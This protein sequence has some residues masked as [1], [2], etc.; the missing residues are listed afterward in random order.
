MSDLNSRQSAIEEVPTEQP[1]I[2]RCKDCKWWERSLNSPYGY[3]NAMKHIYMSAHWEIRMI[4]RYK[5]DFY[6]ADAERNEE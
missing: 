4:R 1:E 3:C 5:G 2:I 6:C